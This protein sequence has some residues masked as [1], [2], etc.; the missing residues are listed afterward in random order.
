MGKNESEGGIISVNKKGKR[1]R[2]GDQATASGRVVR[3]GG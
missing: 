2:R 1:G 3:R